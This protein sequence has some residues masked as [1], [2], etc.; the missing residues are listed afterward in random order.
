MSFLLQDNSDVP[1]TYPCFCALTVCK[2]GRQAGG[3]RANILVRFN[4]SILQDNNLT[5]TS[6]LTYKQCKS[7]ELCQLTHM[8]NVTGDTWHYKLWLTGVAQQCWLKEPYN[9]CL[10]SSM[11][12]SVAKNFVL[13]FLLWYTP[14]TKYMQTTGMVKSRNTICPRNHH[15][16]MSL[17]FMYKWRPVHATLCA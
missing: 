8:C 16:C 1:I 12:F 17:Y 2:A 7:V 15:M 10:C 9:N 11:T 13:L 3:W 6:W 14:T 5:H 4:P